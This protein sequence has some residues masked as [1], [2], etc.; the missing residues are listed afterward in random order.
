M[1]REVRGAYERLVAAF[2]EGDETKVCLLRRRRDGGGRRA[3]V[4][5]PRRVPIRM[6]PLGGRAGPPLSVDTRTVELRTFGDV[7]VLTHSI[8]GRQRTDVGDAEHEIEN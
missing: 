3:M 4:R 1:E 8:D 6:G 2:R 5:F 7:A